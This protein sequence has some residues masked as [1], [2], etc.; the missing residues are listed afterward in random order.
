MTSEAGGRIAVETAMDSEAAGI[1]SS[2][3]NPETRTVFGRK[4]VTGTIGRHT[5]TVCAAGMGRSAAAAG[6]QLLMDVAHPTALF[7]SGIAGSIDPAISVADIVVGDE[8][9][10]KETNEE[11]IAGSFPFRGYFN[12]DKG[13]E[14]L[15]IE[16]LEAEGYHRVDSLAEKAAKAGEG[17]R[18]ETGGPAGDPQANARIARKGSVSARALHDEIMD[19]TRHRFT[20]GVITTSDMFNTDPA[21]F[22]E[23]RRKLHGECEECEGAAAAHIA[24]MCSVPFLAIRSI[25]NVCGLEYSEMDGIEAASDWTA[26]E[27][28]RATVGVIRRM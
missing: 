4:V 26:D 9:R 25:S 11:L 19:P 5:V 12:S 7:F 10:Y 6:A 14:R 8:L 13:L 1:V 18:V 21:V 2:L 24:L 27:A 17:E 15:A 28:A 16:E 3:E 22:E 23:S 20:V